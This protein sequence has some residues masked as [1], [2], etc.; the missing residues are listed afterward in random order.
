MSD[1][2]FLIHTDWKDLF[3]AVAF[4]LI[5]GIRLIYQAYL[6]R[7]RDKTANPGD[8]AELLLVVVPKN[9]LVVYALYLIL[10]GVPRNLV[11]GIGWALFLFGIGLRMV[12]LYQLGRMYSLNVEIRETH[13]L[14]THGVYALVRHPLYLAYI[15]DTIGIVLFLQK[16]YLWSVVVCVIIGWTIRIRTEETALKQALGVVYAKYAQDV[17]SLNIIAGAYRRLIS[18]ST[19]EGAS[20]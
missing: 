16:W 5:Y 13:D 19:K 12:A 15:L 10:L 11:F 8:W 20:N 1:S 3:V 2:H 4:A 17:P 9:I 6:L 14:V 7:H 18:F